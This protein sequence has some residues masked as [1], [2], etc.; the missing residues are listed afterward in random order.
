M[1][2]DFMGGVNLFV[3]VWKVNRF[4]VKEKGKVTLDYTA[5]LMVMKGVTEVRSSTVHNVTLRGGVGET[6]RFRTSSNNLQLFNPV[7]CRHGDLSAILSSRPWGSCS[8]EEA[9]S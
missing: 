8:V 4:A 2:V 6:T 9:F 1:A 3:F 5:G 7:S